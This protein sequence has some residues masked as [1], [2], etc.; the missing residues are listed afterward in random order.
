MGTMISYVVVPYQVYQ[1]TQSSF[2]VG[3]LGAFQAIPVLFLGLWGGAIA[4]RMDRRKLLLVSEGLMSVGTLVLAFNAWLS[5]PNLYLIFAMAAFLQAVNARHA[6]GNRQREAGDEN[7]LGRG[8]IGRRRPDPTE[9][10]QAFLFLRRGRL[11][12]RGCAAGRQVV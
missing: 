1:L 10:V 2:S 9:E 3:L 8:A 7:A 5:K 4:D 12:P 6:A 11:W